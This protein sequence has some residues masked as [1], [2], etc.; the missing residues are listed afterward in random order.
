[1][2][3]GSSTSQPLHDR[4][5]GTACER[6]MTRLRSTLDA[7]AEFL[8]HLHTPDETVWKYFWPVLTLALR[9][10]QA[11]VALSGD[12]VMAPDEIMQIRNRNTA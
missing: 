10:A 1:M 11:A 12:F 2:G 5:A 4:R 7:V 8:L 9:E 6:G 3:E